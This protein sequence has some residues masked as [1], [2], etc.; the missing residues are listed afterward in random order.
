MEYLYGNQNLTLNKDLSD[1]FLSNG[2]I[3][4]SVYE[5]MIKEIAQLPSNALLSISIKK[6]IISIYLIIYE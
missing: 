4:L 6:K 5:T 3:A 1:Q 2:I